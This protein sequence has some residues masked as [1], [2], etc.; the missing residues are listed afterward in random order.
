MKFYKKY[1]LAA[2]SSAV[3]LT[4]CT[5]RFEGLN[6]AENGFTDSQLTQDF[7]HVKA[8]FAPM[9]NNVYTYDPA[10]VTQLQQNLIGDVY[11]GYMMPPTPFASNINNMNYALVDGWN[12]FPWSTAYSNI[13]S[14]ALKVEQRAK[15]SAPQFY[16]WS[17]ILKVEAMHRVS[18]IY[19]PLVY[20][21]FGTE[22]TTIPYDSQQDVYNKFFEELD[23]AINDLTTRVNAGETSSFTGTDFTLYNGDYTGWI[24]F[25]NSL[26]LRLAMRIVNADPS[27]AQIEAEKSLSHSIGV[28]TS[29]AESAIVNSSTFTHPLVTI[30][31]S[32]NDIRMGAPM[33]S[34]LKG[35]DDPR[36]ENYFETS[37]IVSGEYKGIRNGIDISDKSDYVVFSPLGN[38]IQTN[39]IT[40]MTAAEVYFLRAEGALRGWNMGGT[41]ES[42]YE[43]GIT[44]SFEQNGAGDASTYI[45]DNTK[46]AIPYVDPLNA[47]NNI[48]LG[49]TNL[50]TITIAWNNGDSNEQKLEKIITQ[51]WI[52]MFPDG[53]EA[54]SEFR[55]TGYPKLFPVVI[56]NSGGEI[57]TED[58]IR[59]INFPT[60]EYDGNP[61]GVQ[62]GVSYLNGP[63][64]GGTRLWWDISGSNF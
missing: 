30:N 42:L 16:A 39:K 43:A 56:N 23:I 36:I 20:S 54:W 51:K 53:Q 55:R 12:G 18:D 60:S 48:N 25:A 28:I 4:A 17:L 41:A 3:L 6:E 47:V 34:I 61:N 27:K 52:A 45:A 9:I 26:R 32:W 24:K 38:I 14:N 31:N 57:S 1:I 19:G 33:E 5:D 13:M 44:T 50:S 29:N 7:N 59:R 63:D 11:S 62:T 37:D 21:E 22:E 8:L 64:T 10:W 40:W 49:D 2:I 58:F 46:T 35:Y 15:E